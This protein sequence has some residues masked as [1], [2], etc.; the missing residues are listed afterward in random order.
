MY[1]INDRSRKKF[2]KELRDLQQSIYLDDCFTETGVSL[3]LKIPD[4]KEFI[5]N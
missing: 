1:F 2:E 4:F 3:N 5:N